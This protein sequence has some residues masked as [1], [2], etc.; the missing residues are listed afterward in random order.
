MTRPKL[1]ELGVPEM[2]GGQY[3]I[4]LKKILK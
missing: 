1:V 4:S 2:E 3:H